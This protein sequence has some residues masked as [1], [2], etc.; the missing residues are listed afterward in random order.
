PACFGERP[1]GARGIGG[2]LAL[3]RERTLCDKLTIVSAQKRCTCNERRPAMARGI[4]TLAEVVEVHSQRI[5]RGR[6]VYRGHNTAGYRRKTAPDALSQKRGR[7][8]CPAAHR[9][10]TRLVALLVQQTI[11]DTGLVE[12]SRCAR[13]RDEDC[14]CNGRI[15]A[16]IARRRP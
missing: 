11:R 5:V 13:S 7:I 12:P 3:D 4:E 1:D 9:V 10:G 15:R 14:S 6:T 8:G 2:R 16:R